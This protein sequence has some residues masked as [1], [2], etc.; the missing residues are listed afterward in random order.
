MWECKSLHSY[1]TAV[2]EVP[3]F[4]APPH[5]LSDRYFLSPQNDKGLHDIPVSQ[6][7]VREGIS[8]KIL[9]KPKSW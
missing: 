6:A 2:N 9:W 7:D 5:P 4:M 8:F 1:L 3:F